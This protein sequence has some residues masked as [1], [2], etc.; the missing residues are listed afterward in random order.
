[1][2]AQFYRVDAFA[3]APFTGNPAAV[4]LLEKSAGDDWMQAVAGEVNA[5]A[6]AFLWPEDGQFQ[7]RWRSPVKELILC[8]HGTLAAA[9]ILWERGVSTAPE[10]QFDTKSGLLTAKR[11]GAYI[12]LDFPAKPEQPAQ[13]ASFVNA[14]GG[15]LGVVPMYVG[16]NE[17]D[18]I[19]ELSSEAEIRALKPNFERLKQLPIRGTIVTAPSKTPGFDFVSRFFAPSVGLNEDFATGSAHCCLGPYWAGK[20]GKKTMTAYQAS[21][22]GA[23][24]RVR[25]E[26][27]RVVLGGR[28][29][30]I[31]EGTLNA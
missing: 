5:P 21:P 28:A 25:V 3:D 4:C 10:H 9:H 22:R 11:S 7:L 23:T 16:R 26:G 2:K 31:C 13:L 18:Y 8:G 19:V 17:F 30:T 29:V 27:D 14:I 24:I 1:M 12:D 20:L 15:A 6:T